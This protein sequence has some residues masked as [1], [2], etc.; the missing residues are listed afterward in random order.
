MMKHTKRAVVLIVAFLFIILGV[1]GLVLPFLQGILFL[2]VGFVLLF[3][4]F[5]ALRDK[6]YKYTVKYPKFHTMLLKVEDYIKG[7][8]GDI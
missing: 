6:S 8:L 3:L 7:I 5:P 1:I 2:C 4:L